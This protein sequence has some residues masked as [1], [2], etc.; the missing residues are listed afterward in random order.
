MT[1]K[2]KK[3]PMEKEMLIAYIEEAMKDSEIR[4]GIRQFVRVTSC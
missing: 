3:A 1:K 4:K 2:L